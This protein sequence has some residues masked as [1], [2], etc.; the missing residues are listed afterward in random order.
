MHLV[1]L[2]CLCDTIANEE[3]VEALVFLPEL[4]LIGIRFSAG[5][6]EHSDL[7][8]NAPDLSSPP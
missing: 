6:C 4:H 1:P 8:S 7:N 3:E 5:A 2:I